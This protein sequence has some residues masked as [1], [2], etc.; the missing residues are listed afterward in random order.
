MILVKIN[1][2]LNQLKIKDQPIIWIYGCKLA[3]NGNGHTVYY[4]H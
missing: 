2:N 1:L 4:N 3:L